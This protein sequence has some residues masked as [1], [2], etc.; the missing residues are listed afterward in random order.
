MRTIISTLRHA[1]TAYNDERRYAGSIDVPLSDR[2][3]QEARSAAARLESH[4]YDA[5]VASRLRRTR[6][7]AEFFAAGGT[8]IVQTRL[9]NERCFGV[10]EGLTWDEV[11]RLDPPVLMI[12]VGSELHTVNPQRGEPF[13]DLWE[14]AK[15]FRR[16]L[17]RRFT[18]RNVLVISHG[19]FL[20]LFHG[21]LRG[22]NCIESL[23]LVPENLELR[24]FE[25][26]DGNLVDESAIKLGS[27][28]EV[29]W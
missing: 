17:F 12:P 29:R 11:Q 9:C 20:Q 3:R 23:A 5:I 16:F 15:Q 25:F 2:G 18:G 27:G 1:R 6:E 19:V 28:R 13:E 14:R 21:Q 8:P 22:T 4:R 24:R 10:M 7:T 26:S